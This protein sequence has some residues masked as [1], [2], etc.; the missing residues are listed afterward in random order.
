MQGPNPAAITV[1]AREARS[2]QAPTFGTNE[3]FAP[4]MRVIYF[5]PTYIEMYVYMRSSILI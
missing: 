5:L 3:N 4:Y 1:I 2:E